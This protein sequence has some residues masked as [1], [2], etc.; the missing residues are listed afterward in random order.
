MNCRIRFT[1]ICMLFATAC[2]REVGDVFDRPAGERAEIAAENLREMLCGEEGGW[3]MPYATPGGKK[4]KI[5]MKFRKNGEVEMLSDYAPDK[6]LSRYE[7]NT[8]QGA[9]LVFSTY[10]LI[11]RLADPA[12]PPY[13]KGYGGDF[14]FVFRRKNNDSIFF[15]GRK[16]GKETLLVRPPSAPGNRTPYMGNLAVYYAFREKMFRTLNKEEN[17]V[18]DIDI[19]GMPEND[20]LLTGE[21]FLNNTVCM[22]FRMQ[23]P[24]G[25]IRESVSGIRPS[26][27]GFTIEPALD[28]DGKSIAEFVWEKN[29]FRAKNAEEIA[30]GYADMPCVENKENVVW[31]LKTANKG[32][33][34]MNAASRNFANRFVFPIRITAGDPELSIQIYPGYSAFALYT[35][36]EIF[37]THWSMAVFDPE[38]KTGERA[39]IIRF[40]PYR[41]QPFVN[42]QL[43]EKIMETTPGYDLY[44]RFLFHPDGVF[45]HREGNTLFLM[46]PG[47]TSLWVAFARIEIK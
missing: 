39:D 3:F 28:I 30:L 14:E 2:S 17:A 29:A 40:E 18:A 8:G 7:V 9:V 12:Y 4:F 13:G 43:W 11:H 24:A 41:E 6:T 38:I 34:M 37:G 47:D 20:F 21:D 26:V 45:L 42:G 22:R 23:K 19:E 46:K 32:F 35:R 25:G 15:E 36:K 31:F 33:F 1:I 5:W 10:A 27:K 16:S 44:Y